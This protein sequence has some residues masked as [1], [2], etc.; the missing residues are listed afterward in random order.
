MHKKDIFI[1]VILL[2]SFSVF[3]EENPGTLFERLLGKYLSGDIEYNELRVTSDGGHN[4]NVFDKKEKISKDFFCQ[5]EL[6]GTMG[7]TQYL[8]YRKY[9]ENDWYFEKK[10][11][12]YQSPYELEGAEITYNY[13]KFSNGMPWVY[14]DITKEYDIRKDIRD[15]VSIYD[16]RNLKEIVDLIEQ[17]MWK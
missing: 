6:L 11:F 16:R 12:F 8:C 2:C 17:N 13:F 5:V 10:V 1:F 9:G 3:S 4:F 14:N 15:F 7:Q